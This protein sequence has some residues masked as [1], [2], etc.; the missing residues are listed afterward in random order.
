M[1]DE[2]T[3]QSDL[4]DD[5][6]RHAERQLEEKLQALRMSALGEPA[7]QATAPVDDDVAVLRP[8]GSA[9]R[10]SEGTP[11]PDAPEPPTAATPEPAPA[12]E[13]AAQQ[14]SPRWRETGGDDVSFAPVDGGNGSASSDHLYV[15]EAEHPLDDDSVADDDDLELVPV[16]SADAA[17][18]RESLSTQVTDL[19]PVWDDEDDGSIP[20]MPPTTMPT[21]RRSDEDRPEPVHASWTDTGRSRREPAQRVTSLPSEDEMQF[22]AHTR[23]ALRNLQQVTDGIAPQVT[24]DVSTEVARLL[25]EQL[26]TTDQALRNLQAEVERT[27]SQEIPQLADRLQEA[28]EQAVAAPN[29]A[30]R[31]VRDEIP[32]QLDKA[33]KA[34]HDNLRDE[35]DRAASSIHGAVQ[36]DVGQLEQSIASNVT[37]LAQ[38]AT[39]A[40]GRVERDVD[41]LGE[42]VVRFE[43][44]VHAEFDRFESQ[45]RGAIERVEQNLRDELVAPSETIRKLDDEL[46]NRFS[47][48]ERALVEQLQAGQ[49]DNSQVLTSLVDAD[50]AAL[51]RLQSLASTLDEDRARRTEDLEVVVDTV[52]TGWEGLAGAMTALFDQ[53][54]EQS[55]R[56]AGIE[57]R[58]GQLRDVEGAM[59]QTLDEFQRHMRDLKPSPIVVT[60]AHD[61][62]EVRNATRS[63][64]TPD[65]K[66]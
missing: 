23:T 53:L 22:W 58:L 60:V 10:A 47:R 49:R 6:I 13:P 36:H 1:A 65:A 8:T 32:A 28:V 14:D 7:P 61:E 24:G 46:P 12:D 55:R 5:A 11:A 54:E 25:H 45:L 38:G 59:Q 63:G 21:T 37:R 17:S 30:I 41:V 66:G 48:I 9:S 29:N 33:V 40:V 39:D 64:W 3:P 42:T 62:A 57:Q 19:T 34:Q 43:R 15:P 50:R 16:D 18:L 31:Q 56:M 2:Q 20:P 35:L 26:G 4:I 44:G 51:D 52:T 27:T